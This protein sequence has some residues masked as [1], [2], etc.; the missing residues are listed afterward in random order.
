MWHAG[1]E[2][3]QPAV[4]A[5]LEATARRLDDPL[6][7]AQALQRRFDH[8]LG[9]ERLDV[10][11]AVA[12]EAL[13][14]AEVAGDHWEIAEALRRKAIAASNIAEL[15]ERVNT[16]ASLLIDVGNIHGLADMLSSATYAALYLGSDRDATDFAARAA[17]VSRATEDRFTR[18]LSSG[19]A[20]LAALLTGETD[21][22]S[23]AFREEL[24]LCR[25]LVVRPVA[26]EGFRGLAAIAVTE[27]N[28]DRAARL[29]GAADAHRFGKATDPVEARLDDTFFDP[30][31][32]RCGARAW[33]AA[34]RDG[35]TLSFV[36][37]IAYALDEPPAQTRAQP[38]T[39]TPALAGRGGP[40]ADNRA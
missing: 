11:D 20:G 6:I 7:L 29:V 3:D 34:A 22:A 13:R 36:D 4:L 10:A 1:R 5:E 19:N 8:E 23:H 21:T 17:P 9:A 24:T 30:A 18:L 35:S 32:A 38:H 37:A 28:D 40:P 14:C 2:G 31:R 25:E 12:D 26:R 33:D 39:T 15:R 16:A 27:G